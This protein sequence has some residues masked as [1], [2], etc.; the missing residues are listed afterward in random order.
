M[1]DIRKIAMGVLF[2]A[3]VI[4]GGFIIGYDMGFQSGASELS[5]VIDDWPEAYKIPTAFIPPAP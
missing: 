3:C 1:I 5:A 4:A 2:L